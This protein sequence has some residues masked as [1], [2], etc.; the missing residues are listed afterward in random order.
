MLK[1]GGMREAFC[2]STVGQR[3]W[4]HHGLT[5]CSPGKG[6]VFGWGALVPRQENGP[7]FLGLSVT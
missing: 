6:A 7:Y 4:G 1:A 5:K 3:G 2:G